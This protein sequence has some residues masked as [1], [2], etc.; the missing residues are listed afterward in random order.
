MLAYVGNRRHNF[1]SPVNP[2]LCESNFFLLDYS[3]EYNIKYKRTRLI[4]H[5][6]PKSPHF[7]FSNNCVK[8]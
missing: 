7:Y 4:L 6:V 3:V 1:V 8:N 2:G 5:Y